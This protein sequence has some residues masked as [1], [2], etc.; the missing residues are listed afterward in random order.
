MNSLARFSS[1][2]CR[3]TWRQAS[4][5][6]SAEAATTACF[7]GR[8]LHF[9]ASG[10]IDNRN[11]H[12]WINTGQRT[13]PNRRKT[14]SII[15]RSFS[16][17]KRSSEASYHSTGLF[18]IPNLQKPADFVK[19][20]GEA[21]EICNSV[22]RDLD[23]KLDEP[24]SADKPYQAHE[25]LYQLDHISKTV[26]NVI[27]AAELCRSV[28]VSKEWRES[29]ERAFAILSSYIGEL[30]ADVTLYQTLIKVTSSPEQ[31]QPPFTEE[32][33]RFCMLL[34]AEFERDGIH[35]PDAER[36]RVQQLQMHVTQLETMFSQNMIHC[37]KEFQIDRSAVDGIFHPDFLK[38]HGITSDT[39]TLTIA[40]DS[41]IA[42]T[43]S[44]FS[45]NPSIRRQVYMESMT[46]CPENLQVLEALIRMRHEV[47]TSLGF[48]SYADRFLRDKMVRNQKNVLTFLQE[49]HQSNQSMFKKE[50]EMLSDAKRKVEGVADGTLEP[51][52]IS[53]YTGILKARNGFDASGISAYLTLDNC[54]EGIKVLADRLFAIKMQ[55]Q[56]MSEDECWDIIGDSTATSQKSGLRRFQFFDENNNPLG[57]MYLDLQ[58]REGKYGHAAHFTVRCG[59]MLSSPYTKGSTPEFQ[60][61]VVALVCNL[62]NSTNGGSSVL[63]HHEVETFFH[64][65]GHALHSLLSR[66]K[67]Q[68]MS[69]TRAAMDFVE[70]PSHWMENYVWDPEFLQI[71]GRHH[72]D[73]HAIP[74]HLVEGLRK[75]RYEFHAVERQNQILYALFDQK[76]FGVPITDPSSPTRVNTAEIFAGLH[77]EHG[78]PYAEGTH[79]Y[80]RFGHL[81]TYG[82]G[83]YG[84]LYSQVFASDI[85]K[86]CFEGNSLSRKAGERLWKKVLIHGGA[87]DPN[88]MLE[89]L[90]GRPPHV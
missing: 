13:Y 72:V 17:K 52:D 43:L 74:D 61:P 81:V 79:W 25:A 54:I 4:L 31:V 19:L 83:Y 33:Q 9:E 44:K 57:T 68:H 82:A 71:L 69:G 16:S 21:V 62:A 46:S 26:C 48:E 24:L 66:T 50:M 84:Y 39:K 40:T 85:W 59:C 58:K 47:S 86:E 35:L 5:R 6:S 63:T 27:D 1:Q 60:L 45:D 7:S 29:A 37:K 23:Q 87:S 11:Y 65:C 28:H 51:W 30:N 64:E 56:T 14:S 73:G 76:L 53:F 12:R 38:A 3:R 77:R 75:S 32:E 34:Q 41:D 80:S 88:V 89:D 10:A 2:Q 42:H 36:E 20:A 15:V 90:L 8:N 22:R 67:F 78:I 49:L 55:E 70:T 18:S